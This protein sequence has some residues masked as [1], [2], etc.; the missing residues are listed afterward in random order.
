MGLK[1]ALAAANWREN[2]LSAKDAAALVPRGAHVFLSSGCA[3]PVTFLQ[4]L[5]DD[6]IAHPGV[7]LYHYLTRER[8]GEPRKPSLKHRTFYV[9]HDMVPLAGQDSVDY[10][11]ISL[12]D[13]TRIQRQG[14]LRID[15]AVVQVSE[16]D[17]GGMCSLGASVG[18]GRAMIEAA[19]LVIAEIN[20]AM[21]RTR[22]DTL[23]PFDRFD[24]AIEVEPAM[25]EYEPVH[26]EDGPSTGAIAGRTF[27]GK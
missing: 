13:V 4:A 6:A 19:D 26:D 21:P 17:A 16:P 1:A 23:I 9:S 22:G 15:V 7:R 27:G 24:A 25:L 14:R 3:T 8:P 18:L 12:R 11:P 5:E 10:I 20:P 2:A